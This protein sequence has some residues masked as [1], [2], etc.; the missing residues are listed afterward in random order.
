MTAGNYYFNRSQ[1][2]YEI[3]L[4]QLINIHLLIFRLKMHQPINSSQALAVEIAHSELIN[5]KDSVAT[6]MFGLGVMQLLIGGLC[7]IFE[8]IG[9]GVCMIGSYYCGIDF[10]G[11]GFWAGFMVRN[12]LMFQM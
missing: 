4:R 3:F 2:C 10:I 8:G 1:T 9:L 11:H 5:M 6:R 12:K 7:I